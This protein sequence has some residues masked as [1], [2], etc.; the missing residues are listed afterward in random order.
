MNNWNIKTN[1][2]PRALILVAHPDDETIFCGGTMLCNPYWDWTVVCMTYEYGSVRI[3]QFQ[4][5][6]EHFKLLGVDI[7]AYLTLEQPNNPKI[8]TQELK[9]A[10]NDKIINLNM[11]PDLVFTHNTEG[12]YGH[13]Y[14]KQ[15]NV[16]VQNHFSNV[17][18][19]ICPGAV[20]I[21]PQ[22][23]KNQINVT[24]LSKK[25]LDQKT[26]IFDRSYS[27]EKVIWEV[28][29]ELMTCEFKTGPEIFT[30]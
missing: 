17:W 27:T 29:P 1:D 9:A 28:Y 10:W 5:A 3:N 8:L 4:K 15:L 20:N 22:P 7:S 21:T 23:F 12:E 30:S 25:I 2:R 19:F 6:M 14:H 18:E 24:P 16:I 13:P 26:N 11:N